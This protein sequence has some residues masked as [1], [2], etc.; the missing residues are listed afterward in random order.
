MHVKRKDNLP[1]LKQIDGSVA[2]SKPAHMALRTAPFASFP[3]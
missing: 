1:L 3:A 2:S